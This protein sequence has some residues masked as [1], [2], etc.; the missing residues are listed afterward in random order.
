MPE[1]SPLTCCPYQDPAQRGEEL[2]AYDLLDEVPIFKNFHGHTVLRVKDGKA[3]AMVDWEPPAGTPERIAKQTPV[4]GKAALTPVGSTVT[5]RRRTNLDAGSSHKRS[6][7]ATTPSDGHSG[8]GQ[9]P[10][11]SGNQGQS[12]PS[13]NP[14]LLQHSGPSGVMVAPSPTAFYPPPMSIFPAQATVAPPFNPSLGSDLNSGVI[15]TSSRDVY[16][17]NGQNYGTST[18]SGLADFTFDIASLSPDYIAA[19]AE[20]MEGAIYPPLQDGAYNTGFGVGNSGGGS[21]C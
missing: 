1:T 18:D 4:K 21:Y 16:N 9:S 17:F 10:Q 6:K 12:P 11:Y 13:V 3:G 8:G 19:M 5:K 14:P 7:T 2:E 15:A 20:A